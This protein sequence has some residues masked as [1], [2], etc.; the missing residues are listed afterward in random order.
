MDFTYIAPIGIKVKH[1][2]LAT[3]HYWIR[4]YNARSH[5][6]LL[7]ILQET[8][9]LQGAL[10]EARE[11]LRDVNY[12]NDQMEDEIRKLATAKEEVENEVGKLL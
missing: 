4:E 8:E 9:D 12:A 5:S 3:D 6:Q 1:Y 7:T 2:S 10:N 11:N